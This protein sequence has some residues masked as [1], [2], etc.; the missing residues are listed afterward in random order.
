M[1]QKIVELRNFVAGT[2]AEL[3]DCRRA[4]KCFNRELKF[5]RILL[6]PEVSKAGVRY[7]PALDEEVAAAHAPSRQPPLV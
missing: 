2:R 3:T 7:Y 4:R 5:C 1:C 6:N